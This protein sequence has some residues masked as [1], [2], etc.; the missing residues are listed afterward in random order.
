[1]TIFLNNVSGE[2]SAIKVGSCS[3]PSII[4]SNNTISN[5]T[6]SISGIEL[7]TQ[8]SNNK[9]DNNCGGPII[10][11]GVNNNVTNVGCP[12]DLELL[13]IIP[14]QVIRDVDMA[15]D[16][17]GIVRVIVRNN[18]FLNATATVNAT[19]DENLLNT[20]Q[21][22]TDTKLVVA[23]QNQTFDFSFKPTQTGT[24]TIKA[25]VKVE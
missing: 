11:N 8:S 9:G 14:I 15:K 4:D 5:N 12:T 23:N 7:T 1:M 3:D 25:D 13:E 21:G 16:K 22:E 6:I 24:R 17:S 20:F 2:Q 19:L 18:G 10:D